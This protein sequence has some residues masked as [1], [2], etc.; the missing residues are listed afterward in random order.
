MINT[1]RIDLFEKVANKY[2]QLKEKSKCM[3]GTFWK[4][5]KISQIG[6]NYRLPAAFILNIFAVFKTGSTFIL[7]FIEL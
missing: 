1:Q 7:F 5:A 2:V 6:Q 4:F 3:C